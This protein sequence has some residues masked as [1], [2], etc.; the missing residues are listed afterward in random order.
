MLFYKLL[1]EDRALFVVKVCNEMYDNDIVN[2][3]DKKSWKA[4]FLLLLERNGELSEVEKQFCEE[5]FIYCFELEITM[6]KWGEPKECD[7]CQTIRY[8]NKYCEQCISLHL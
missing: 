4:Y 7:K 1:S 2:A 6:Y 3:S 5:W 8:S